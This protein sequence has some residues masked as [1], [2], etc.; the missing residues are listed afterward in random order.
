MT[1]L[2]PYQQW[3]DRLIELID[4]TQG[5]A[6]WQWKCGDPETGDRMALSKQAAN[7]LGLSWDIMIAESKKF[8]HVCCDCEIAFN[9]PE[10]E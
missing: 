1:T 4:F 8:S 10:D 7:E 3:T 9:R 6:G 5:D 2:T